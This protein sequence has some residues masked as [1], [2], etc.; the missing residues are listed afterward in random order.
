[1]EWINVPDPASPELD[2]LAKRYNLHPLHIE[3]C[4]HRDQRAKIEEGDGYLFTVL[5]AIRVDE[6]GEF[7]EVDLDIFLG[8][9]FLITVLETDCPELRDLVERVRKV[10]PPDSKSDRVYHRIVDEVV[11]SYLPI[12]DR[13]NETIDDLEDQAL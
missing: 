7:D 6:K 9:D 8:Q 11:D 1:M 12:L 5:K 3:D 13:L 4:R 2:R 10:M